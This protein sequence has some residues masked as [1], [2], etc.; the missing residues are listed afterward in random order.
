MTPLQPQ[1]SLCI[2]AK[3]AAKV[4]ERAIRSVMP[5]VREVSLV[6]DASTDGTTKL[7]SNFCEKNGIAFIGHRIHPMSH[8]LYRL[9]HASSF[10][11]FDGEPFPGPFSGR[12]MLCDFSAARNLGWQACTS[13][14]I[15]TLDCDDVLLNANELSEN[16]RWAEDAKTSFLHC[17]YDIANAENSHGMR[18][19]AARRGTTW[20][21]RIHEHLGVGESTF[22]GSL[23]VRDM[24]DS[25]NERIPNHYFKIAYLTCQEAGWDSVPIHEL[26]SAVM[27]MFHARHPKFH[28]VFDLLAKR[29][30]GTE[31][32][33]FVRKV[34]GS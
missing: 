31:L 25:G 9:D 7:V 19:F 11:S 15:V 34:T 16:I 21:G 3:N 10:E 28:S 13:D 33:G 14:W 20:N 30:V 26:G 17:H 23:F 27:D 5:H 2:L 1:I 18:C 6:D 32:L 22:N 8:P 29:A 24:R 12:F 4:I